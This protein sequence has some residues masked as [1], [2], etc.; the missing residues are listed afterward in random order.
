ML[1][2]PT[3]LSQV[4]ARSGKLR[5]I[6][7]KSRD[8]PFYNPTVLGITNGLKTRGYRSGDKIDLIIFS[9]TGKSEED[10][11][12]ISEAISK[13]PDLMITLGTDAS[14][15]VS[16]QKSAIPT[17]FSMILDPVSLG[18]VK[19]LDAPGGS[20]TGTTLLVSPGK[21]FDAL[22]QAAPKVRSIGV[23]YTAKD[24][25]SLAFLAEAAHDAKS[26]NLV[27]NSIPVDSAQSSIDALNAYKEH[28]DALWF[29]PDPASTSAK[30]LAESLEYADSHHLPILGA[31]GG[32]VKAGALVALSAA[33]EDL[34]DITSE[35]ASFILAGADT[36]AQM[37]VR[38]PRRT[39]LSVNLSAAK[40]LGITIPA[41]MLHLADE[42][43][44]NQKEDN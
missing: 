41:T 35:M 15:L 27:I 1:V 8:N 13:K 5:V 11:T 16:A 2:D 28:L 24:S 32:T 40:R 31:S 30:A 44:E 12:L 36:P 38:G 37:R 26:L 25:T 14:R 29:I 7:I 10:H 19:S 6:V 22:L 39:L 20:F 42:V 9:M 18:L 34:G 21:Q 43:I 23:L 17:L 4:A 33:L 3:T